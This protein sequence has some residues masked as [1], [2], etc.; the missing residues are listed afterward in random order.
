MNNH[1]ETKNTKIYNENTEVIRV[2]KDIKHMLLI[3]MCLKKYEITE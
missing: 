2:S 1:V 3:K